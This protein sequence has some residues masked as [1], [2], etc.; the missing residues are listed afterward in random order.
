MIHVTEFNDLQHLSI[1]KV[2]NSSQEEPLICSQQPLEMKDET[3]SQLLITYF[4]QPFTNN[5]EYFRF[6]HEADLQLNEVFQYCKRIFEDREVFHEQSV[7]IAK[8]LYKH[9]THPK[10]KGGELYVAY[11]SRCQVDGEEVAAVGIFKSENR[12]TYLKVFLADE[13]YQ[14]NYDDGIN[15]NK[16]DKGCL[17]FNIAEEEGYKVSVVDSISKQT[18][19]VYWKDA[20]LQVQRVEDSYHQTEVAV[21]M[22]KQ[23]ISNKLPTEYE[24]NKV[25]QMDLLNKSAAYFKEKEQFNMDDF[26]EEVLGHPEAI[27]S[28]REYKDHFQSEHQ[29][30][31]PD[32]FDISSHAVKKQQKVFKSVLK[33]DKN[34]HVYIHG[35]RDLVERG[36]DE[37]TNM[38]Y[39]K[40]LFENES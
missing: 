31:L 16:L 18:E 36:F 2:G 24:M 33:L 30:P 39:Y 12:D 32:E 7:N 23:F 11:F 21:N 26:A 4:I 38:Y 35:N 8:H 6:Y 9:S 1:H 10:I 14:V 17:I 40:L 27:A 5:A 29:Q 37:A 3:I 15:I 25:D 13:N 20:F 22:C 34:F 28:F 19:A